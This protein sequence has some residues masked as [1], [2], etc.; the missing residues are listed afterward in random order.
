LIN[1]GVGGFYY[2]RDYHDGRGLNLL[3]RKGLEVGYTP[4]H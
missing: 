4:W 2:H 1:A 3:H